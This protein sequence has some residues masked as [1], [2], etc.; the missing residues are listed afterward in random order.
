MELTLQL[1]LV[2]TPHQHTALLTT[3]HV[4]NAARRRRMGPISALRR[5]SLLSN[6][7]PSTVTTSCVTADERLLS[8]KGPTH[9]SLLTLQG[10]QRITMVYGEYQAGYLQRLKG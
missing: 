7:S 9:V 5:A 3:M 8:W 6:P 4:F 1:K 10:R 2:P